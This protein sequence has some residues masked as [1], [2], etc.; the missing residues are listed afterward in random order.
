MMNRI[1]AKLD[2]FLLTVRNAPL[3]ARLLGL[4]FLLGPP[5]AICGLYLSVYS[6][7]V[8][9]GKAPG[10]IALLFT[11]LLFCYTVFIMLFV[12][13]SPPRAEDMESIHSLADMNTDS[14]HGSS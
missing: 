5:W 4:C 6:G 3:W 1:N 10:F 13:W 8:V 12:L 11:I 2:S 9:D 7:D 14:P